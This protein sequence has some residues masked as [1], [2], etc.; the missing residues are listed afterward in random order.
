MAF[1]FPNAP[2][3]GQKYPQPPVPGVPVWTWDGEKWTTQTQTGIG[4][5]RYDMPQ[6]LTANQMAQARSNIAVMRKN[7]IINGA[8]MVSQENGTTAGAT[9][10][11]YPVDMFPCYAI[12][13][14]GA[15]G[16]AQAAAA[17]PAGSPTRLG[18]YVTTADATVSGGKLVC[19]DTSIEGLRAA[20]LRF[21]TAS[22]KTV[23]LQ[24]GVRASAAG[25]YC[26]TLR[27][28]AA[29]R[30]YVSEYA[31]SAAEAGTD[32][33]KSVVISGDTTGTWAT[34]NTGGILI[35]WALM[36]GPTYQQ[37]AGSWGAVASASGSPNQFNVMGSTSNTFQL[38]D[39]GFYEGNVAPPF[40]VPD[41]TSE[42]AACRRYY[43]KS[44]APNTAP[45][46]AVSAGS[47]T[48]YLSGAP[49][50][51][52]M[53]GHIIFPVSLR[54]APTVTIYDNAGTAGK[55]SYYTGSWANNGSVT[56]L[57]TG[58]NGLGFTAPTSGVA[59]MYNFDVVAN[60]RL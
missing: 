4:A 49:A 46:T 1:D 3:V 35:R 43:F 34:D 22:A 60:A 33:V 45:G 39:V 5:V 15:M 59:M 8:M 47:N 23:T 29:N 7:Y 51:S 52:T 28:A 50:A 21:G 44:Y 9:S 25:T 14:T 38:F 57:N 48:I 17:T 18:F 54:I 56:I 6:G 20:D 27:N 32:V 12:A 55:A 41:Y 24:F 11:Y 10:G 40:M 58:G 30:S 42:L 36:C 19:I 37:A 31:I 16:V 13:T 26:V 2:T 53:G